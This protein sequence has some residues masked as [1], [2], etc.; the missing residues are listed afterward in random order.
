MESFVASACVH[1]MYVVAATVTVLCILSILDAIYLPRVSPKDASHLPERPP[2]VSVIVPA[3][4]EEKNIR[5]CLRSLV[6][7][8]YPD[9]EIIV[10]DD[11]S[12]DNTAAIVLQMAAEEP[13]IRL[14]KGKRP[15][16]TWLGK[17]HA[18]HQ[19]VLVAQGSWFLFVDAD[20][21][22]HPHSIS[23]C[24]HH[25]LT[26]KVDMLSLYPHFVCESF[27]EKVVQPAVGRIILFAAP[28]WLVNSTAKIWRI[29]YMAIGQ[30]ILIRKDT[31]EAVG[32]HAAIR[33]LV[34]ED[35]E[36]AKRVKKAGYRLHFLYGIDL[37]H[38]RMYT[39][40]SEMWRGWSRSF[41]PGMGNSV[42]IALIDT[43]LLFIFGTLPYLSLPITGLLLVA[44]LD[45]PVVRT[46][47]T[48]SLYTWAII[49]VTTLIVRWRLKEYPS[50][51]FTCPLGGIMVQWIALHSIY[52]YT[53]NKKVL[54]KGRNLV[55]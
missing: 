52:A 16:G 9:Y 34:T 48:I 32:G 23:S 27:W 21:W 46:I 25:C 55:S 12:T 38:T 50:H 2:M 37:L 26:H 28:L 45:V 31:Y 22:H 19:G 35:V 51:F 29:F 47:F 1:V 13:R 8:D 7:Q 18:L 42:P 3:R 20:T 15:T 4:N 10:V 36:L 40:F 30:F 49:F 33:S 44:G 24:M 6:D 41:Y 53:C 14:V 54:W 17:S 43:S 5:S 11:R 39:R